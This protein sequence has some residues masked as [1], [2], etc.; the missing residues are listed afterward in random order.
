M[1]GK[2]RINNITQKFEILA[3]DGK[4]YPLDDRF[5]GWH[6]IYDGCE[7]NYHLTNK[8][9]TDDS[10]CKCLDKSYEDTLTCK[11]FVGG[12]IN[13]CMQIDSIIHKVAALEWPRMTLEEME[14]VDS[15]V[16]EFHKFASKYPD[17]EPTNEE[18]LKEFKEINGLTKPRLW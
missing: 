16:L 8:Y 17:D 18:I 7:V 9:T 11:H 4:I 1:K 10:K 15:F 14:S 5:Q 2:L 12:G 13:D 3:E 6:W